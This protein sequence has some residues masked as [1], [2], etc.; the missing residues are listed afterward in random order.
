MPE[1]IKTDRAIR[2]YLLGQIADESVLEQIEELMFRDPQYCAKME[3][4]EDEIINDYVLGELSSEEATSFEGTL[5]RDSERLFKLELARGLEQRAR[6]RDAEVASRPSPAAAWWQFLRRPQF[7]VGFAVL[8][9]AAIVLTIYVTRRTG[10]DDLA[11]L[12]SMYRQSRPTE[13]RISGFDYAPLIQQRGEPDPGH[14]NHLRLLENRLIIATE[15]SPGART[16]SALATFHLTQNR[17]REAIKEFEAALKYDDKNA[18]IHNDLGSAHFELAKAGPKEKRFEELTLG[19]EEFT[20][21]TE[22]NPNLLEALFNRSLALQ[23]LGLLRQARESWTLY[24]QKD[25]SSPWADE[26]RKNLARI[27]NEQSLFKSDDDVLKDFLIA[28]R[29][30]DAARAQQIHNE[31]KGLLRGTTVPL[32]LARRYLM[33]ERT[34]DAAAAKEFADALTFVGDYEQAQHHDAFFLS[35]RNSI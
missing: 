4:L 18:Q 28:Y 26:A 15:K 33:A 22:L 7:A 25:S 19:L 30:R 35:W 8:L 12:R 10:S 21:A 13:S 27:P 20:R 9:I 3:L 14:Q 31:T 2:E 6:Q 5:A 29:Q 16:F 32:Q 23:E 34:N 17:Q 24:L 11:D 1:F